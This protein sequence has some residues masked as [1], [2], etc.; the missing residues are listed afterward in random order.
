MADHA[1]GGTQSAQSRPGVSRSLSTPPKRTLDLPQLH[2]TSDA[3]HP[4][5]SASDFHSAAA[6]S[7]AVVRRPRRG[8]TYDEVRNERILDPIEGSAAFEGIELEEKDIKRLPKKVNY[9][10]LEYWS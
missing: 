8:M 2:P 10:F 3:F 6:S 4:H 1:P 7:S 5:E 9:R